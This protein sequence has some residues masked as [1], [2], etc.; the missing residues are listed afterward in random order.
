MQI[1]FGGFREWFSLA[2][3]PDDVV[4]QG[5]VTAGTGR[6]GTETLRQA[7][8]I[9]RGGGARTHQVYFGIRD[10]EKFTLILFT[11]S[12]EGVYES[13]LP[14]FDAMAA[15]WDPRG[16]FPDAGEGPAGK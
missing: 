13:H 9:D 14:A 6:G 4:E 10:G 15:S 12:G 3:K 1:G 2:Q 8:V 7:R 11:A 16:R 5:A